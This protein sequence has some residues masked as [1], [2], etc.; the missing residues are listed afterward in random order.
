[1]STPRERLAIVRQKP[2]DKLLCVAEAAAK[3]I[4][5]IRLSK[6]ANPMDHLKIDIIEGRPGPWLHLYS[7]INVG[8]NGKDPVSFVWILM[9]D[10]DIYEREYEA[11][12]GPLPDSEEY[13][14][15]VAAAGT[16]PW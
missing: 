4:E 16:L 12:S 1:M 10:A 14:A 9:P 5:R 13:K 2:I 6:W 8:C 11:Y 15:A 7:P 3:G